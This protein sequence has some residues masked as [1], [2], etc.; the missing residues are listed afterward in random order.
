[1]HTHHHN[2]KFYIRLL[3]SL[4]VSAIFAVILAYVFVLPVSFYLN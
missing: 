3:V 4:D 2:Y 1:M